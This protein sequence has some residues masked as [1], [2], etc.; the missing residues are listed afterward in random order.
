MADEAQ[1]P[2]APVQAQPTWVQYIESEAKVL[3]AT[4][5]EIVCEASGMGLLGAVNDMQSRAPWDKASSKT[6]DLFMQIVTKL[7]AQR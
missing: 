6:R 3:Y 2:A 5:S 1:Q 4:M 7:R